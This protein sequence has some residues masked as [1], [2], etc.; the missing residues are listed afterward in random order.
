MMQC[1]CGFLINS[2]EKS[3]IRIVIMSSYNHILYGIIY[4][5]TIHNSAKPTRYC[6]AYVFHILCVAYHCNIYRNRVLCAY[7]K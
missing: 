2:L 5:P 6:E 4:Q 3:Y 1:F 7:V